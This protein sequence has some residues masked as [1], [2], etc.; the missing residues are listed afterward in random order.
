MFKTEKLLIA[1][2]YG[3]VSTILVFF[4]SFEFWEFGFEAQMGINTPFEG[5]T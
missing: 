3:Q 5:A 1:N 4:V 2:G